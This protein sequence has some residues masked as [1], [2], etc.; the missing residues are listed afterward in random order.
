MNAHVGACCSTAYL[1]PELVLS[2]AQELDRI[3]SNERGPL[4]GVAI[5]VKDVI[6]TKGTC[7]HIFGSKINRIFTR[8]IDMPTQYNSPLYTGHHPTV[9]AGCI[10]VLRAAG[11]L[12]F[13]SSRSLTL[14]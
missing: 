7:D 3:P 2:S 11:A 4:H 8:V 13:G 6:Y 5:G 9:D 12:I 1:D 14:L 10:Q